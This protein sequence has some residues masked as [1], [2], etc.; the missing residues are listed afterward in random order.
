MNP[1]HG[2]A[3]GFYA[4]L[5]RI[6]APG[7]AGGIITVAL[8]FSTDVHS[9]MLK[10]GVEVGQPVVVSR[11]VASGVSGIVSIVAR[12]S[13]VLSYVDGF[14]LVFWMGIVALILSATLKQ[15]PPNPLTPPRPV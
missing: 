6:F 14:Y 10:A 8:R 3:I 11:T 4:P 1:A 13:A 9:V 15:A 7:I 12:E 5:A 2:V